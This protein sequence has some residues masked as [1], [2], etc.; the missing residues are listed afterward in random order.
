VSNKNAAEPG[1]KA[2]LVATV[3]TEKKTGFGRA[4]LVVSNGQFATP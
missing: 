3:I 4:L 1:L 2:L